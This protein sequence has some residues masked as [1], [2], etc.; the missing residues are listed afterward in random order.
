MRISWNFLLGIEEFNY[1][2]QRTITF[3]HIKN[4]TNNDISRTSHY[5]KASVN[6]FVKH[7]TYTMF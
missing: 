7:K 4:H 5:I 1:L 6:C 3:P 2:S